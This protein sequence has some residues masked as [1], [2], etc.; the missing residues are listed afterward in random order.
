MTFITEVQR[1]TPVLDQVDV[2][3]VGS[4][5][6]GLAAAIAAARAGVR[7]MLI[8]RYGC[9]GGNLTAA[10]VESLAWYRHEKT[11][12]SE[13]IGIEF[14]R[15]AVEMGAASPEPQ[16]DSHA[17]NTELFKHVADQLVTE[18]GVIPLLHCFGVAPILEGPAITGVITESK[19][20]RQAILA[21]VVIDA[22]GDAD[23]AFRAGAPCVQSPVFHRQAVTM[24]FS[25]CGIDKKGF[26]DYIQSDPATYGDWGEDWAQQTS[27]LESDMFS[28]YLQKQFERAMDAGVIRESDWDFC[29]SWSTISDDGQAS[30]LNLVH[31]GNVDILDIRDLTRA[32]MAG[33]EQVLEA[34]KAMNYAVPGFEK[35]RLRNFAM[36][37]GTR[38]SRKIEGEYNLTADDVMTEARFEDSIGIFPEFV[39]GFGTLRLPVT[40]RYFQIPY[41]SLLPL[42]IEN[43]LVAGRTIAGDKISHAATRN[44]MCC[45]VSG[46][47]A[48][49]AAAVAVKTGL[50]C[51]QTPV[52]K[53]QHLLAA[54]G[55]RCRY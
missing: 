25:C 47:G 52:E 55:V 15:R 49:A 39:D 6:G 29:G 4:G 30:Y 33:R 24:V 3:V 11:I 48:G 36:T 19:S 42:K 22:S 38:D 31:L 7:T 20:G 51:R 9:F 27:G 37:L 17:L 41:R 54:Q 1:K 35:A 44:M 40:G 12:D 28:P 8:E 13:G 43:L 32:E 18:A 45:A 10:G 53:I 14:E 26:M 2:L 34:I 46:Q 23:I 5:P 16:S 50:P 21:K